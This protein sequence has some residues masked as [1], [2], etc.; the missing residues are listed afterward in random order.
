[1]NRPNW[2]Q[3]LREQITLKALL[4]KQIKAFVNRFAAALERSELR[5]L[6]DA[7]SRF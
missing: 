5:E 3:L 6:K 4:P 2:A 1:M 7:D